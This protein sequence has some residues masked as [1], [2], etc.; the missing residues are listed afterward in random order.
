MLVAGILGLGVLKL[1][2][3]RPLIR[4]ALAVVVMAVTLGVVL[5][6]STTTVLRVRFATIADLEGEEANVLRVRRW[7][8]SLRILGPTSL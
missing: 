3:F 6:D 7:M 2:G 8:D 1:R 5:G 4:I